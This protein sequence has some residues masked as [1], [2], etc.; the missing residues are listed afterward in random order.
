[1]R[2]GGHGHD[3]D[4]SALAAS[5]GAAAVEVVDLVKHYGGRPAVDGLSFTA[6][7]GGV[8][9]VL[10]PNGAG[11]TT[12]IE[13]CE[14]LRTPDSGTIRV[15]GLDPRR[16]AAR[17]RQRVGVM[18]QEG[19]VYGGVDSR[20]ALQHAARLYPQPL[21]VGSLLER[22][23]LSDV[24]RTAY[25]RLSG[26]QQRRLALALALVGRPELVFLDEPTAGLDPQARL[27]VAELV[28][29]LRRCGTHVVLTTHDMAEA[30]TL[31]DHVVIV[32]SGRVVAA[33]APGDLVRQDGRRV[34]V[35][36]FTAPPGLDVETLV[37]SLPT[38][39]DD[40]RV[41]GNEPAPGSYELSG[42]GLD[43][44]TLTRVTLW[45]AERDVVPGQLGLRP[46]GLND[47]FLD[48]TG[49]ELRP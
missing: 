38:P 3:A 44:S 28:Q 40:A 19:G 33:G 43:A 45:C 2:P 4:G 21:P 8:T 12:T 36:H 34:T 37:S 29:E 16:D 1:V 31:A 20:A 27:A 46:R 17:V 14:G 42:P 30:E 25:R 22:L 24:Q 9:A 5:D 49:R 47:V 10:G 26:G 6:P 39:T 41:V 13:A 7:R 23:G 32:D 35:V 11:K 15:L 48:L 18:L